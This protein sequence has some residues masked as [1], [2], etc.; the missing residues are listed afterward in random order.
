MKSDVSTKW[1]IRVTAPWDHI[2]TKVEVLRSWIDHQHSAVGYHIGTKTDKP[3]AHIVLNLLKGLQKQSLDVRVKQLFGVKG[4]DYSSKIWDGN[5]KALSYLYHDKGGEV[6]M[7]IPMTPDELAHVQALVE[8][9]KEM[10]NDKKQKASTRMVDKILLEIQNKGPQTELQIYERIF[11]GVSEGEWYNPAFN[12]RKYVEEI[13]LRQGSGE[14]KMNTVKNMA[15]M[16]YEFH[17]RK[18]S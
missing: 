1:A 17:N 10:V 4:S 5:H 11:T 14:D 12:L 7:K 2:K 15:Q 9:Y 6:D 8:V 3:H 13:L 18:F 16:Y